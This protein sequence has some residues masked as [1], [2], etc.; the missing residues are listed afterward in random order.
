MLRRCLVV[1]AVTGVLSTPAFA[2]E[3]RV[4]VSGMFGYTLS[5]GVSFTGTPVAGSI[6]D[7]VDPAGG[8]SMNFTF[9]VYATEQSEVEFLWSHQASTLEITGAGPMLSGD[10]NV[11]TFHGNFIYNVGDEGMVARPFIFIGLGATTYG[12]AKFTARTLPGLT[13]FSWALGGG[14][15][16]YPSRHVGVKAMARWVPT[17]IHSTG[18]GWWCDPFYGCGVAGNMNYANQFEISGGITARF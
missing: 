12:D 10:M 5:E 1:L 15:K 18:Y 13:K 7:R 16:A 8:V 2:Q 9:G 6:Y 11:D 14:V 3:S 4:E 17:Y